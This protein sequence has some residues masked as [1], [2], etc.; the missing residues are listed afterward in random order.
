MSRHKTHYEIYLSEPNESD[1]Q[2][3]SIL[4]CGAEYAEKTSTLSALVTCKNCIR[5]MEKDSK[6]KGGSIC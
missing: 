4:A 5:N 2:G 6:N 3:D 1:T